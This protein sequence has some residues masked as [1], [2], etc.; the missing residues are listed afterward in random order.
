M[1]GFGGIIR[2]VGV[3][4]LFLA[5][6][7]RLPLVRR[8]TD[9]PPYN[10]GDGRRCG[11]PRADA[12]RGRRTRRPRRLIGPGHGGALG[13]LTWTD[14]EVSFEDATEVSRRCIASLFGYD[15]DLFAV[16]QERFCGFKAREMYFVCYGSVHDRPEA[17]I[18]EASRAPHFPYD[19]LNG[20]LAAGVDTDKLQGVVHALV[21]MT[22]S[23]G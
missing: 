8:R 7:A 9:D 21:E 16:Q 14:T 13:P 22:E 5:G 10:P 3:M 23:K 19:V 4:V 17:K 15:I 2:L 18:G 12:L 20:Y 6:L 1:V 11:D